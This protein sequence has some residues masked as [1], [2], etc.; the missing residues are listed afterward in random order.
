MCIFRI[1]GLLK[2]PQCTTT[3]KP[4]TVLTENVRRFMKRI[5]QYIT[6]MG[7][8]YTTGILDMFKVI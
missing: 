5:I 4:N 8:N 2:K 1:S 7:T 6:S 3:K